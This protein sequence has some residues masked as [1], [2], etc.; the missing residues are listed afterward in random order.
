MCYGMK[1]KYEQAWTGECTLSPSV[2]GSDSMPGDVECMKEEEEQIDGNT[3]AS[4]R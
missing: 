4:N 2:L 3:S 1:C